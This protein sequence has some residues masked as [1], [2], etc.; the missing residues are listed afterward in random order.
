MSWWAAVAITMYLCG[1]VVFLASNEVRIRRIR[2][3]ISR[4]RTNPSA[5]REKETTE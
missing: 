3:E 5:T 2:R 4:E 1:L